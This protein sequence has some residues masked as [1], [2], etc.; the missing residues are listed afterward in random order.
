MCLLLV[1]LVPI[2]SGQIS[3]FDNNFPPAPATRRVLPQNRAVN[4]GVV[5]GGG[6]RTSAALLLQ[7]EQ[8]SV[9]G[10][11]HRL[12]ADQQISQTHEQNDHE[13]GGQLPADDVN[14]GQPIVQTQV[15]SLATTRK[16]FIQ[17]TSRPSTGGALPTTRQP[18]IQRQPQQQT[19]Q[20]FEDI[21][22]LQV[23]F[24]EGNIGSDEQLTQKQDST[25]TDISMED[26]STEGGV[27]S[28]GGQG[29]QGGQQTG[30]TSADDLV[31]T[32]PRTTTTVVT[33]T[34][35]A[36]NG[37]QQRK[38]IQKPKTGGVNGGVGGG[39]ARRQPSKT[40]GTVVNTGTVG[41]KSSKTV[42]SAMRRKPAVII[43]RQPAVTMISQ[44]ADDTTTDDDGD[45]STQ[46]IAQGFDGQQQQQP[47]QQQTDDGVS[48]GDDGHQQQQQV[49]QQTPTTDDMSVRGGGGSDD[50]TG[51]YHGG[52]GGD[53][54]DGGAGHD[55]HHG[56]G[57]PIQWLRDAV[58]GEPGA[59]YPIFYEPPETGFKCQEQQYPGY[60]ADM[61]A[62]CQVFHICQENGRSDAFLCPNGTIFSQQNFVCVW[63]HDFDC[64][65]ASQYYS[66]NSMLYTAPAAPAQADSQPLSPPTDSGFER[67]VT[68]TSDGK[69][70][71]LD[72]PRRTGGGGGGGGRRPT[73]AE[74]LTPT[75]VDSDVIGGRPDS[76]GGP[77]DERIQTGIDLSDDV[78]QQQ[79]QHE[80]GSVLDT[81]APKTQSVVTVGSVLE[82]DVVMITGVD[83]DIATATTA[84][85]TQQQQQT[86]LRSPNGR[87]IGGIKT[88][89]KTGV[90][91]K[92]INGVKEVVVKRPTK[93][94]V[95]PSRSMTR[96]PTKK[97]LPGPQRI[98]TTRP[99]EITGP[100]K[101]TI[102]TATGAKGQP[103]SSSSGAPLSPADTGR[104]N[105]GQ[106]TTPQKPQQDFVQTV[107]K[108]RGPTGAT[109]TVFH[110]IAQR[111]EEQEAQQQQQSA[112]NWYYSFNL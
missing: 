57:D 41:Q 34:T 11:D 33:T 92:T 67:P 9:S 51:Q 38:G 26:V 81:E 68:T 3:F 110:R 85:P 102:A 104:R 62:R 46:T 39:G 29:G 82:D 75:V 40:T 61:E 80:F 37:G 56:S 87:P 21:P 27:S 91:R 30:F 14:D 8:P 16:P 18:P 54:V 96:K 79:Q 32:T 1:V 4:N 93:G 77:A 59:D 5:S 36:L 31:I 90:R 20:Q 69:Q 48:G 6:G 42:P 95:G 22:Q 19:Q 53:D 50:T 74:E 49:D 2:I 78:Q 103:S 44:M 112:S 24:D 43:N 52:G 60:Y 94:D 55:H 58:R 106:K 99:I 12:V 35:G 47:Q 23:A 88:G 63:W 84:T 73:T 76:A 101:K 71:E 72:T 13:F 97:P 98:T 70:P 100:A 10:D 109:K 66:L 45:G 28:G 64:A 108:P 89:V 83:E 111:Q 86:G 105:G 7:E 107:S 65:T 15:P 17:Q 25:L